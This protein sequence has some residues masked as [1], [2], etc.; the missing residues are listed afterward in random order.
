MA[1]YAKRAG[2]STVQM[3]LGIAGLVA[4]VWMLVAPF[5]LNYGGITV[6]DAKTKKPVSAEI[7]AVTT[8]DIIVGILL[9]ALVAFTLFTVNNAAVAKLRYYAAV[10]VILV[11]IYLI[12]APYLFDLLKVA[13]YMGLDVPNTND[14]LMG[15]LT[16]V[17]GG[18]FYQSQYVSAEYSRS[19][20][21]P[22]TA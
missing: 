10:A 16:V 15:I 13:E 7:G 1:N 5:V 3:V 8:N 20:N 12:A 17:L 21:T 14:Q 11:G 2:L 19:A 4:G 6:L 9:I 22:A 18:Y